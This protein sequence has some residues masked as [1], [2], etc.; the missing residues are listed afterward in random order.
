MKRTLTFA[1]GFA[2]GYVAG[3]RAGTEKYT[4]IQARA[5][6]VADHP[7]I[8]EARDTMRKTMDSLSAAA[9]AKVADAAPDAPPRADDAAP[10]DAGFAD[11]S[12]TRPDLRRV[13]RPGD[14][15]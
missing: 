3:A 8:A 12:P 15:I 11:V 7:V 1:A 2:A 6:Q 14:A 4:Q 13:P 5:R 9:T 10:V